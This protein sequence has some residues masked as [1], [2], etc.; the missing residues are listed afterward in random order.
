MKA[1]ETLD[2]Y[3]HNATSIR[4]KLVEFNNFFSENDQE[5]ICI[6]ETWLH[7]GVCDGEILDN[8][9][10]SIYRKDRDLTQ[11]KKKDGGGVL[12]AVKSDLTSYRRQ[13]LENDALE[14]LWVEIKLSRKSIFLATVYLPPYFN[15]ETITSLDRNISTVTSKMK[16]HDSIIIAGD[17][18]CRDILWDYDESG[19]I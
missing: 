8:V 16:P 1:Q 11:T 4:G 2:V 6:T 13:D 15:V 5:A 10:Y 17:F 12:C 19:I 18:N 9:K 7:E 3:Y 14:V